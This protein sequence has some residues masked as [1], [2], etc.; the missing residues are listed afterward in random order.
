MS[1]ARPASAIGAPAGAE[2]VQAPEARARARRW[3]RLEAA[4]VPVAILIAWQG[5]SASGAFPAYAFPPPAAVF[6]TL[7]KMAADGSLAL[8][9]V[10]S[11]GRQ[12]VG[13]LLAI[14]LG[15]PAGLLLGTS[16]RVR[17]ALMPTFRLFYPIPGIAWVPLAILWFGIGFQALVFSI[18]TTCFFPIMMNTFAGVAALDPTHRMVMQVFGTPRWLAYR[19]VILPSA[20][21]FVMAGLRL[22][23]GVGWRVIIGAEMIGATSGLGYMIDNARWQMRP[24]IVL[25]GMVAIGVIGLAIETAFFD[26]LERRTIGKWSA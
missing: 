5:L 20:M 16:D 6:R 22:A 8:H 2:V 19:R 7:A 18:F 24:D 21:P 4:L 15:F 9:V 26:F 11:F 3:G 23:Y 25:G 10:E 14:L 17:E 13:F 12:L 1:D